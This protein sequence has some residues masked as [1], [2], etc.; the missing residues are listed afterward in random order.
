MFDSIEVHDHGTDDTILNGCS[1]IRNSPVR[2][3]LLSY[4]AQ[5]AKQYHAARKP[6][7]EERACKNGKAMQDRVLK[8]PSVKSPLRKGFH[9]SEIDSICFG[10][11][12]RCFKQVTGEVRSTTPARRSSDRQNIQNTCRSHENRECSCDR[13]C[14]PLSWW[15]ESEIGRSAGGS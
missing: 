10:A 3:D 4:S 8:Q 11:G 6:A 7:V 12:A 2:S 13:A 9:C 1:T 14:E 15:R 5:F